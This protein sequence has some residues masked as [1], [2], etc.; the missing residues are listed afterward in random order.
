MESGRS[1]DVSSEQSSPVLSLWTL[2]LGDLFS[3]DGLVNF[4]SLILLCI[5]LLIPRLFYLIIFL[6]VSLYLLM[7]LVQRFL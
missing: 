7:P 1:E 5:A 6:S 2:F 3:Y 4:L